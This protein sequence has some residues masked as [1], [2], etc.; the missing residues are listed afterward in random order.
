[1]I[2]YTGTY[3][4]FTKLGLIG[5]FIS[6]INTFQKSLVNV[7][8]PAL[9][10]KF[11]SNGK[12]KIVLNYI[13][14]VDSQISS[15]SSL[16][17]GV[18]VDVAEGVLI[19]SVTTNDPLIPATV[20]DCLIELVSQMKNDNITV[21]KITNTVT[22]SDPSGLNLV[23]VSLVNSD[24]GPNQH[25]IAEKIRLEV[26]SDSFTGGTAPGNE[27][28]TVITKDAAEDVF[29]Y[30]Y[31]AGSG[32][33]VT[34]ER[35]NMNASSS[36]GNSVTNGN[37]NLF[38]LDT[39]TIPNNWNAITSYGVA[40]TNWLISSNG[41]KIQNLASVRLQQDISSSVK[42][43]NVY[44]VHF[45]F[46]LNSSVVLSSGSITVDLVDSSGNTMVDNSNTYLA[47]S[48]LFSSIDLA[49][50]G[51]YQD[52]DA[53]FV[54]GSKT[55]TTVFL[56]IMCNGTNQTG[57]TVELNRLVL[58][59]MQEL[60]DGGPY[61]SL[62]GLDSDTLY[63]GQRIDITITKSLDGGG[64]FTNNTFQV[65]FDRLFEMSSKGITL[66]SSTVPTVLDSLI[67]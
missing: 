17:P 61:I 52:V 26:T 28:L 62:L 9:V 58:T 32:S 67:A 63:S 5:G 12:T 60:Y 24:G 8:S 25:T 42:A 51:V 27:T 46:K 21:Q 49:N 36:E 48:V 19:D 47:K 43:K 65:L 44:H 1:M 34:L 64:T 59:E 54:V 11:T 4:L 23:R 7:K 16:V 45:R 40:G 3:G 66:P 22:V 13:P 10:N 15:V 55:P 39:P 57:V 6:D 35:T 41:L 53:T 18:F 2:D 50:L 20:E 31:P 30:D 37:F 56:R 29:N 38:D 33:T 14:A